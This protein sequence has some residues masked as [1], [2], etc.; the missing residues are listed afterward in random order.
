MRRCI[1]RIRPF[2]VCMDAQVPVST[3]DWLEL[4]CMRASAGVA[5]L[6]ARP[7]CRGVVLQLFLCLQHSLCD[8]PAGF[9]G[10]EADAVWRRVHTCGRASCDCSDVCGIFFCVGSGEKCAEC[11]MHRPSSIVHHP[12][13]ILL[14]DGCHQGLNK[15]FR[16][17]SVACAAQSS[18]TNR[19]WFLACGLMVPS[20]FT[21]SIR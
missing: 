18:G 7:S 10:S 20:S 14:H 3:A 1:C 4:P 17:L 11:V 16:S 8:R 19:Q 6:V 13:S 21:Y 5:C 15:I 12:S 2:A 9:R